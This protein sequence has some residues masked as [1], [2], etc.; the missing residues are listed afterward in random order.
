MLQKRDNKSCG[1]LL[2]TNTVLFTA[3]PRN[4][5]KNSDNETCGLGDL[6]ARSRGLLSSPSSMHSSL[7]HSDLYDWLSHGPVDP[8]VNTQGTQMPLGNVDFSVPGLRWGLTM[9]PRL[10]WESWQSSSLFPECGD[11][12]ST[13]PCLIC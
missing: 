3:S 4:T 8:S 13:L 11:P 2:L 5:L 7:T 10:T 6:Q 12:R 1:R 9:E